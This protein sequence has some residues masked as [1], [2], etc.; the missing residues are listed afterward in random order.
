M[1]ACRKN[2][3]ILTYWSY[4]DAL[5]QTYTLPYV[6]L[7]AEC[8]EEDGKIF[9]LT[10]DKSEQPQF[11]KIPKIHNLSIPYKP[12]GI[13]AMFLWL[14]T[15]IKLLILIRK[16]KITTIHAWCTPAGM[17]GYL[18]S[19]LTGKELIIDSFEPHA[20]TMIEN[21]VWKK[22]SF[23][24][25]LLFKF[26]KLQAHRA[27]HLISISEKMCDYAAIKYG[28][29]KQ[30]YF[31]KPA[32]V[33]LDLFSYKNKKNPALL[34]ELNLE[35]KLVCVYA[36]KFGGIYLEKEA[37]DFF[38]IAEGFWG[39]DFRVLI[40][41]SSTE[42]EIDEFRIN[43][44]LKKETIIQRF[45]PHAQIPDYIGLGDFAITPVKPI[46]TKRYCSPIKDGEYWA[47]GL[48]VVITKNISDDS[49]I[50]KKNNIG[51]VL[52]NLN[53]EA[54]LKSVK[55]I[56]ELLKNQTR[57]DLYS[58]IRAIAESHRNFNIA[59]KIYNTIYN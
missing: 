7:I 11:E 35:N 37:F 4:N 3:L 43:S 51:S 50:I 22:N 10:L 53:N 1:S 57:K 40:L 41:T 14:R 29:H 42:K 30:N 49:D 58:K 17:I 8:L 25:R 5:I 6:K 27:K 2:I 23:A 47:L 15:I 52:D 59:K 56:D 38:K 24:F 33:N 44:G 20:E 32:C 28:H 16:E 19:V 54:Y 31:V 12:V 9:L 45:V 55:E 21:G 13:A 39:N 48:P 34:K 36:G 46:E 26:E 18:L